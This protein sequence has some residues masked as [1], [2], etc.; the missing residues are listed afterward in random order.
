MQDS[1]RRYWMEL[2][3]AS[4]EVVHRR[5][6]E[7]DGEV[8]LR[9]LESIIPPVAKAR[10]RKSV[11]ANLAGISQRHVRVIQEYAAGKDLTEIAAEKNQ[12]AEV[13]CEF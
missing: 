9:V 5:L 11:R 13:F 6:A 7:N 10:R 2:C 8:A 4:F 3:E 1:Q 12:V